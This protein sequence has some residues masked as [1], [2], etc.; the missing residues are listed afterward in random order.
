MSRGIVN[1]LKTVCGQSRNRQIGPC[2]YFGKPSGVDQFAG[3]LN[4]SD[5][6]PIRIAGIL[7]V[8]AS[9]RRFEAAAIRWRE[10]FRCHAA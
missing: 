6:L 9:Q 4:T 1:Q 3:F 7:L 5:D 8:K 2:R 10:L